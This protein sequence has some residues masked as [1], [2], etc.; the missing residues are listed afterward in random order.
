GVGDFITVSSQTYSAALKEAYAT[1][2]ASQGQQDVDSSLS[3]A[4]ED[5]WFFA[6]AYY[7]QLASMNNGATNTAMP[8]LSLSFSGPEADS[9]SPMHSH[10]NNTEAANVLLSLI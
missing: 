3:Q 1:Y 7:Y 8:K 5:G 10:R 4:K 6:G 2:L 9:S